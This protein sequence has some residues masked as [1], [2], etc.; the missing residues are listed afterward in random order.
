MA[1]LTRV[2]ILFCGQGMSTLIEVYN[3]GD[4]TQAP[5]NLVL[6]DFG[7]NQRHAEHAATYVVERLKRQASPKF[8]YVIIS[9]QD[10]DHLS[11]LGALT[12]A[13]KAAGLTV[14]TP[15]V[16]AGGCNWS[17]ANK[18]RLQ[19]FLSPDALTKLIVNAPYQSHYKDATKASEVDELIAFGNTHVRVLIS[20]LKLSSGGEDIIRNASSA[21][22]V[23]EN[24]YRSI[25][26]PGDSTYHTMN[27]INTMSNIWDA[28]P[29]L[30][31]T[32]RGVEVPHHGALRT[33][34]ENYTAGL[35]TDDYDFKIIKTFV[36]TLQPEIVAA[37]AGPANTHN[38][39]IKEVLDVFVDYSDFVK[40]H[41]YVAYVFDKSK[42]KKHDGWEQ[43]STDDAIYTTVERYDVSNGDYWWGHRIIDLPTKP[44]QSIEETV[45][46]VPVGTTRELFGTERPPQAK[47]RPIFTAP[48]P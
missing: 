11:L 26:L 1:Q 35:T 23:V 6:L 7:G 33:S 45:S 9:H 5:D 21:V 4:P 37:S 3:G 24:G 47:R 18:K 25:V 2:A 42:S 38:H 32:V 41:P 17:A 8:D 29:K 36:K 22:I 39:P 40:A 27:A 14:P 28:S 16:F 30:V 12:D 43:L 31:P 48:A 44:G 13:I 15:N 46:F 20:G 34:V 19:N 10:G